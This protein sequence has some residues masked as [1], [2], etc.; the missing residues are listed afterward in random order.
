MLKPYQ[1]AHLAA[2]VKTSITLHPNP[3]AEE[4]PISHE[5]QTDNFMED[6]ELCLKDLVDKDTV[7]PSYKKVKCDP[8][9]DFLVNYY[10]S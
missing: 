4:N 5:H 6:W 1:V 10:G 7:L 2:F 9:L 8:C 3:P